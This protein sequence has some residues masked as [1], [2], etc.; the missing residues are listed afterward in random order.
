MRA[1]VLQ[2]IAIEGPGRLAPF[3]E[4]RGWTLETVALYAGAQLPE[5]PLY[6][7]LIV[8]GHRTYRYL[9]AFSVDFHPHWRTPM[10]PSTRA[11]SR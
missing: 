11:S 6:W 5:Q 7:F 8:K 9:S 4:Q 3:L 10:P 2:H 1:L